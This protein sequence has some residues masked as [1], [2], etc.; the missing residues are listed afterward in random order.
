MLNRQYGSATPSSVAPVVHPEDG[1]PNEGFNRRTA[2]IPPRLV[3]TG[4][5]IRGGFSSRGMNHGNPRSQAARR[6][7]WRGRP[8]DRFPND[9]R[10]STTEKTAEATTSNPKPPSISRDVPSHST[11]PSPK[12]PATSWMSH[13][14]FPLKRRKLDDEPQTTTAMPPPIPTPRP[15]TALPSRMRTEGQ[16]ADSRGQKTTPVT[17]AV[18]SPTPKSIITGK[19]LKPAP[20]EPIFVKDE[21]PIPVPIV[22]ERR[23]VTTS[24]NRFPLPENCKKSNDGGKDHHQE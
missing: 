3:P 1:Q 8:R 7:S 17:Q 23:L 20:P 21:S 13:P 16:S 4:P 24:V 15:R 6:G 19:A 10:R 9:A 18:P 5:R 22:P 12:P 11:V 2:N 14:M